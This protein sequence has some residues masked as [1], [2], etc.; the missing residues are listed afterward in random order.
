[1]VTHVTPAGGNVFSDLGFSDGQAI[2][3]KLRAELMAKIS[4]WIRS[5]GLKQDQAAKL[6]NVSRPRISDIMTG[7][8]N[9][10]TVDSLAVMLASTGHDINI[11]VSE[12]RRSVLRSAIPM[13]G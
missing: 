2:K 12:P 13:S 7:K 9:K 11:S 5:N 1:M 3:L 6:L 10:F 8:A 4:E